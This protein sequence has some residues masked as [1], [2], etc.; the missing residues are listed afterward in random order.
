MYVWL[1]REHRLPVDTE[2]ALA[3][4]NDGRVVPKQ[5]RDAVTVLRVSYSKILPAF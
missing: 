3:W 1:E 4:R 2:T 5:K